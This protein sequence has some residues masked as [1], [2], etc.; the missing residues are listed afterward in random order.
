[1][2][3]R[4]DHVLSLKRSKE[5]LANRENADQ[6]DGKKAA[7]ENHADRPLRPNNPARTASARVTASQVSTWR[8]SP[9]SLENMK[10]R[11]SINYRPLFQFASKLLRLRTR[12]SAD[13]L[14]GSKLPAR[15]EKRYL[16]PYG[17]LSMWI[18]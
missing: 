2:M 3:F 6:D 10:K 14:L 7:A 4:P 15:T 9:T 11:V 16:C 1:M 18:R 8:N 5:N 17:R 12:S 13:R